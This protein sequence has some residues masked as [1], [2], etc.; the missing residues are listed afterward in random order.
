MILRS[1][2]ARPSDA[3][4]AEWVRGKLMAY[5]VPVAFKIVDDLP[6]T[7]SMK[8]STPAVRELF[9]GRPIAG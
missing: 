2:A 3:E 1:G 9:A 8:V 4:L 5:C 7:P 6:R